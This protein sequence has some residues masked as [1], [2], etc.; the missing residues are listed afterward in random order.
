VVLVNE[1]GGGEL[2]C[3]VVE[4]KGLGEAALV[5]VEAV[6][7]CLCGWAVEVSLEAQAAEVLISL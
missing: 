1:A 7:R 5:V 2:G 6:G 3:V 4:R